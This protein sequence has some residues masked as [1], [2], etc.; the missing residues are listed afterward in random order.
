[1]FNLTQPFSRLPISQRN[2]MIAPTLL[3]AVL[4]FTP[5]LHQLVSVNKICAFRYSELEQLPFAIIYSNVAG[6]WWGCVYCVVV[7]MWFL[8]NVRRRWSLLL[9]RVVGMLRSLLV[10]LHGVSLRSRWML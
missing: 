6:R 8:R 2:E 3:K 5:V 9:K 7:P 4:K 10:V 1:M